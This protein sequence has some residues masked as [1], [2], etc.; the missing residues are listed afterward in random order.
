LH[1][2]AALNKA[3]E[4]AVHQ[5]GDSAV[6]DHEDHGDAFWSTISLLV[7]AEVSPR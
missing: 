3:R 4:S 1:A 7:A 2:V 6:D 5:G